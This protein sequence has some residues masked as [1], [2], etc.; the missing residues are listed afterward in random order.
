M[1]IGLAIAASA[2]LLAVAVLWRDYPSLDYHDPN[3]YESLEAPVDPN[4]PYGVTDYYRVP[5]FAELSLKVATGLLAL[6]GVA[7]LTVKMLPGRKVWAGG[8]ATA[9]SAILCLVALRIAMVQ[10]LGGSYWP[11]LSSLVA[12]GVVGI[13]ALLFGAA[14]SWITTSRWPNKSLERTRER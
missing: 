13:A 4:A 10:I 7:V 2:I 5:S 11:N 14:A 1:V 8:I 9:C 3:Q 6:L 12:V